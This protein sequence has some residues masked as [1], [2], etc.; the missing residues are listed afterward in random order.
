MG[1]KTNRCGGIMKDKVLQIPPSKIVAP[2]P[3]DLLYEKG[4]IKTK[5][6]PGDLLKREGLGPRVNNNIDLDNQKKNNDYDDKPRDRFEDA[7][8]YDKGSFDMKSEKPKNKRNYTK[9][10]YEHLADNPHNRAANK[11]NPV[12]GSVLYKK[13]GSGKGG[14]VLKGTTPGHFTVTRIQA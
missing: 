8:G 5:D 1:N 2:A 9:N 14:K 3:A 11:N 7:M 6:Y 4:K 12:K 10:N 13:Y